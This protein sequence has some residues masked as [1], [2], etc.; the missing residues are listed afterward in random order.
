MILVDT[1]IW[2]DHLHTGDPVMDRLLREDTVVLHP[3]VLGEIAL[4]NLKDRKRVLAELDTIPAAGMVANEDV[5]ELIHQQELAGS[6]IG[7]IDAHLIASTLLVGDDLLW[8]RDRRLAAVAHRLGI[9][10]TSD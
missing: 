7:L 10:A 2:I 5:L 3:F 9:D 4:G 1:S 6:G 8:T